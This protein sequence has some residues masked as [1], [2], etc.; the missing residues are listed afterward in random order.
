VESYRPYSSYKPSGKGWLGEIPE[1]WEVKRL[2]YASIRSAIYG[3]NE[4]SDSYIDEGVRFIRTTDIDDF[5]ILNPSN[6][7]YVDNK[8]LKDYIL[9]DGDFLFSRSGTIGRTFVFNSDLHDVC[10]YAG[11]LV[12]F[13]LGKHLLSQFLFYFSKTIQFKDWLSFS[14]IQSTIGNINGQKYAN[15]PIIIPPLPEQQSIAAFLDRET[16]K[17]DD[18]TSKYQRLIELLQEKRTALITK[19]V[20]RGLDPNVSFKNSG[21][22]WLGNIPSHWKLKRVREIG[23]LKGGSGFPDDEQGLQD[24]EIPFYKVSDMNL[25]GNETFLIVANNYISKG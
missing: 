21:D 1:H 9:N 19:A 4:P 15:M 12:K 18:L 5:G 23:I 7:V 11:Y 22:K 3:A 24:E 6:P 17:I 14:V 25:H 2:K 10:A 20:T 8:N 16:T 13:V